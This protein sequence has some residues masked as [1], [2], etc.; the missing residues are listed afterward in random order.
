MLESNR[1]VTVL[2]QRVI[3]LTFKPSLNIYY[4]WDCSKK[5]KIKHVV[6]T[7]KK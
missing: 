6:N 1:P 5:K 3:S 4:L 7:L 2:C